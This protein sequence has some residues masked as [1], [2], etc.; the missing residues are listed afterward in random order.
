[1]EGDT[2]ICANCGHR[3]E[4]NKHG[5][6][7]A[8]ESEQVFPERATQVRRGYRFCPGWSLVVAAAGNVGGS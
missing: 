7:E 6:C 3:G 8:C 2:F 5:R 4:L 1:M